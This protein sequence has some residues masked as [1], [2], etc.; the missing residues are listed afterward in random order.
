MKK[1]LIKPQ[2]KSFYI[3]ETPAVVLDITASTRYYRTSLLTE[4]RLI[5]LIS[6]HEPPTET[7]WTLEKES[8]DFDILIGLAEALAA[9]RLVITFNGTSFDLPHLTKK[10]EAYR[11]DNPFREK[12]H[13][14]LLLR[15]KQ[16]DPL[17]RLPSHKLA[18]YM[19]LFPE[20]EVQCAPSDAEKELLL[21]SL[22]LLERFPVGSFAVSAARNEGERLLLELAPD[23]H[24]PAKIHAEDGLFT[25]DASGDKVNLT[26]AVFD[27]YLRRYY[28]N[29]SD[30]EFLPKEGYAVHKSVSASVAKSRKEKAVRENCFTLFRCTDAFLSDEQALRR[31]AVSVFSYLLTG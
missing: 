1:Q 25:L 30:Y 12:A 6:E 28:T 26:A 4:V 22:L 16:F 2:I 11:L 18:G 10:Y 7:V 21:T 27:G 8:D 9:I 17:L 20:N 5:T 24:L 3:P 29:V 13:L 31:Y 19:T 15:L 14:D 23:F